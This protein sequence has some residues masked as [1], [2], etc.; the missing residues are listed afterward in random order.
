MAYL[1]VLA[2]LLNMA[3]RA[4]W[5]NCTVG[6][7]EEMK[8]VEDLKER[9]KDFDPNQWLLQT[10]PKGQ[11]WVWSVMAEHYSS[12][13]YNQPLRKLTLRYP[14][15]LQFWFTFLA[16]KLT[17]LFDRNYSWLL[18]VPVSPLHRK[19]E[20]QITRPWTFPISIIYTTK[21]LPNCDVELWG[22][23]C[24][25]NPSGSLEQCLL[26]FESRGQQ[27]MLPTGD[28]SADYSIFNLFLKFIHS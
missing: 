11:H 24:R 7:E 26:T 15:A 18:K 9:F 17:P 5:R 27:L 4:D 25:L 20:F 19:M 3:D 28:S 14:W 10:K 6:K 13:S 16:P 2:G 22:C 8:M 21:S 12:R 23:L 1:Q